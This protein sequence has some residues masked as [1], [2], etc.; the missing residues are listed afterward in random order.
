[1]S[2]AVMPPTQVAEGRADRDRRDR[3]RDSIIGQSSDDAAARTPRSRPAQPAVAAA[4]QPS[5]PSSLS[6]SR[7]PPL[8]P[9]ATAESS[10]SSTR[11]AGSGGNGNA[12]ATSS[13]DQKKKTNDKWVESVDYAYEYVPVAQTR[14]GRKN[15]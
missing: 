13:A 15:M 11:S 9:N 7:A 4:R 1:M 5:P 2:S 10:G 8:S 14:E 3:D 12:T 6:R